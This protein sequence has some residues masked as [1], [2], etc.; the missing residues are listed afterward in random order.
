MKATS[1]CADSPGDCRWRRSAPRCAT[2][3]GLACVVNMTVLRRVLAMLT[4]WLLAASQ[5]SAAGALVALEHPRTVRVDANLRLPLEQMLATSP[6]FKAQCD[7]LDAQDKLVVLLRLDP[8]LPKSRFRAKS[9]IRRYSSGLLVVTVA[10]APSADQAEW[11]AHEFEHVLEVLDGH[12]QRVSGQALERGTFRAVDGMIE[13][14]R[15][16]TV[17]RTVLLETKAID[18]SDKFVE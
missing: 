1:L 14:A 16:T 5:A 18:V 2:G 13:T 17:G 3:L 12:H 10:V 4:C 15:A 7:R 6:T 11:I 8:T 9:T